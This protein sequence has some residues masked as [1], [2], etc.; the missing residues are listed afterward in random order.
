M[1]AAAIGWKPSDLTAPRGFIELLIAQEAQ[2]HQQPVWVPV[3]TRGI[4]D[5][6]ATSETPN[7]L[8]M[9]LTYGLRAAPTQRQQAPAQRN[10]QHPGAPN[11]T[12]S[13][14]STSAASTSDPLVW[15]LAVRV[16][17]YS[18][19]TLDESL[20]QVPSNYVQSRLDPRDMWILA[21]GQM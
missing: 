8:P 11:A 14:N 9:L 15:G 17:S 19:E 6:S 5:L 1:L 16:T 7:A 18:A 20:F 10:E 21:I 4:L 13:G 12:Q 2:G 3:M